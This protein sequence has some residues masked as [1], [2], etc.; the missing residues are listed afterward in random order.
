MT[1]NMYIIN[2]IYLSPTNLPPSWD[3]NLIVLLGFIFL[4]VITFKE[5]IPQKVKFDEELNWTVLIQLGEKLS[6]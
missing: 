3:W 5:H 6:F 1:Q 2:N 4:V